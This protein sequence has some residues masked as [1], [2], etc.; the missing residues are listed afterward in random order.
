MAST[1]A[2][3][4]VEEVFRYNHLEKPSLT[5]HYPEI[6]TYYVYGDDSTAYMTHVMDYYPNF[7]QVCFIVDYSS[8][9]DHAL[10]SRGPIFV[11]NVN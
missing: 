3:V 2:H 8:Y 10:F 5:P 4:Q 1:K 11:E 6:M 9:M 7:Q